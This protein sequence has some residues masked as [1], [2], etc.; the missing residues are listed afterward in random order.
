MKKI[1]LFM[2]LTFAAQQ[3]SHASAFHLNEQGIDKAF[4]QSTVLEPAAY[5]ANI[6][7]KK[8]T[9]FAGESDKKMIAGILGIV[10]GSFGIHRFYLHHNKAGLVYLAWTLCSAGVITIISVVTFGVGTILYPLV[11]AS[12][13]VGVVDGIMYL[14]ADDFDT[15]YA[16]NSKIIQW[17]GK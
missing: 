15:K 16:N 12:W 9:N 7:L 14:I 17:I 3:F 4:A 8:Q 2:L 11:S 1:I 6:V 5:F 13:I 10:C